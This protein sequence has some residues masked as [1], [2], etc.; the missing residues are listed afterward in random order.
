MKI[1][2]LKS[3]ICAFLIAFALFPCVTFAD[4]SD[5]LGKSSQQTGFMSEADPLPYGLYRAGSQTIF[6]V[7]ADKVTDFLASKHTNKYVTV[8][9]MES[10]GATILQLTG[11]LENSESASALVKFGLCTYDASSDLFESGDGLFSYSSGGRAK[12]FTISKSTLT[13]GVYYYCFVRNSDAVG[14]A[15]G[16]VYCTAQ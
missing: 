10:I 8:Y 2:R 15:F 11:S 14:F 6:S 9:K 4:N 16:N 12:A 13:R 5:V 7:R 3:F 1:K